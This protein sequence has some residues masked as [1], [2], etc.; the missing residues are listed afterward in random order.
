MTCGGRDI[1]EDAGSGKRLLNGFFV[2]A[3]AVLIFLLFIFAT[4][5]LMRWLA[6]L[7]MRGGLREANLWFFLNAAQL[8]T[9]SLLAA[10]VLLVVRFLEG[11]KIRTLGF[12]RARLVRETFAGACAGASLVGAVVLVMAAFGCVTLESPSAQPTGFRAAGVLLV[13]FLGYAVQ[14]GAEELV[15]RGWILT[16]VSARHNRFAGVALSTLFFT[17]CH[18][19]N[20]GVN[21]LACLNLA[22][23]GVL[24][25]LCTFR[26]NSL[27]SACGFHAAW[28]FSL[29]NLFGLDV[30]GV[31]SYFGTAID[32]VTRGNPLIT[33]GTF[34]PEAGLPVSAALTLGILWFLSTG[35]GRKEAAQQTRPRIG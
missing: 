24:M 5:R 1:V 12:C 22:L 18:A 34:G 17:A 27:W 4:G 35:K 6:V 31:P 3:I 26:T 15:S 30:S 20:P 9:F 33:G 21:A 10:P 19:L 8:Y 2:L 29:G 13:L 11:R 14:G 7:W 25:C 28:N 16:S 32:L 23:F